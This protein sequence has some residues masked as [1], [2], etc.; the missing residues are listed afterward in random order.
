[1]ITAEDAYKLVEKYREKEDV[2][3]I[4]I[5]KD[6]ERDIKDRAKRGFT[7]LEYTIPTFYFSAINTWLIDYGFRVIYL[8]SGTKINLCIFWE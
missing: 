3:L 6:I 2:E 8:R 4:Q 5:K 7:S 1:M